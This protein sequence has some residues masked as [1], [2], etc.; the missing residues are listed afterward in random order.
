MYPTKTKSWIQKKKKAQ[1]KHLRQNYHLVCF[2][3]AVDFWAW[4][5]P[6]SMV[7]IV[8]EIPLE[9]NDFS[10]A[11]GCQLQIACWHF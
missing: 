8:N 7:Y 9:K 4:G 10:F 1:T 5:L 6:S 11:N 3:L 2:V